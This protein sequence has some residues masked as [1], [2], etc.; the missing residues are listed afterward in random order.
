MKSLLILRHLQVE[1]ANAVAGMT[2]GFPAMSHFLG[3]T[4]ALSRRI[5]SEYNLPISALK[6]C[7]VIC[8]QHD[9]QAYRPSQWGDFR[10]A[11]TRNPLTKKGDTASFNEEGRMQMTISLLIECDFIA[12]EVVSPDLDTEAAVEV[13]KQ[14]VSK[15]VFRQRLAGGTLTDLRH[16]DFEELPDDP[17]TMA[18]FAR[19]QLLSL[20]PGYAIVDRTD[21]LQQHYQQLCSQHSE[22]EMLNAWLDF[23]TLKYGAAEPDE[24]DETGETS[25][26]AWQLLSK[27]ASGWLVPLFIGYQAISA[28]YE[29]GVVARVR[30][31][32][33][34][35]RF[36]EPVYGVGEWISPHR[37]KTLNDIIWRYCK[38]GDGYLCKN[39]CATETIR[40][41]N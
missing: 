4:H 33:V 22:V 13:F 9:V 41:H 18:Q 35:F 34:P 10:F 31:P 29:P 1:N 40:T 27:P 30:D 19:K 32:D 15:E 26:T 28:L 12:D 17:N 24:A 21:L 16:I 36:V 20:L 11:L 39:H 25:H 37:I 8:H 5:S 2:Y 14:F 23:V 38:E 6:G 3:F 7:A